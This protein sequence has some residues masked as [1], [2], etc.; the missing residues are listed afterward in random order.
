MP[1]QNRDTLC[2]HDCRYLTVVCNS[3]TFVSLI[4]DYNHHIKADVHKKNVQGFSNHI[5]DP[6]RIPLVFR[7]ND[8]P[9]VQSKTEVNKDGGSTELV[10]YPII[11]IHSKIIT[12]SATA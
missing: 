8:L 10:L 12:I 2:R 5:G 1:I 9:T 11:T 4:Q 7:L 3:E 6:K